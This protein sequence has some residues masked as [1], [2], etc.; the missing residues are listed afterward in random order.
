MTKKNVFYFEITSKFSKTAKAIFRVK[1]EVN[2]EWSDH[3]FFARLKL[4]GFDKENC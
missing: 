3:M 2:L 4:R 1:I